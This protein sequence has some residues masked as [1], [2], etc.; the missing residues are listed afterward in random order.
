MNQKSQAA[1]SLKSYNTFAIDAKTPEIHEFASV[2][3]LKKLIVLLREK[4]FILLGGGSNTIFTAD[5]ERP[6]I[7]NKLSGVHFFS[8][9]ER[10]FVS[11]AGGESWQ[12]LVSDTVSNGF[13]GIE[14]L[15]L[16]P[17]SVGAAPVQNIGAYGVEIKDRLIEIKVL[18]VDSLAIKT[19][20]NQECRFSYRDSRFKHDWKNRYII[21]EI[22][23]ELFKENH[24]VLNYPGLKDYFLDR[25]QNTLASKEIYDRI[26][27]IRQS[28]LPDPSL[29]PNA[30]SF[31]KN[32]IVSESQFAAIQKEFDDIVWY[33]MPD[34][35]IKL[36]AG[37]L[38]D[39]AGWKGRGIGPVGMHEKQALVMVNFGDASGEDVVAFTHRLQ[40]DIRDKFGVELEPEPVF[41]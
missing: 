14:N 36:A 9:G 31:F 17:G 37:W 27:F 16:I 4:D 26:C 29:L 23:L 34:G 35:Q 13:F 32:P 6:V 21:L 18:D 10:H 15:A 41:I 38:L 8:E 24:C 33:P 30:G 39:R 1:Q 25:D 19:I 5:T 28:K 12:K 7:V 40:D 22:T 20:T 11:A 2:E 3:A